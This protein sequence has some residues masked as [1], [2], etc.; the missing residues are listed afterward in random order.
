MSGKPRKRRR[1]A[2]GSLLVAVN[3]LVFLFLFSFVEISYR[4]YR[5]GFPRAFIGLANDLLRVPYSN[6]G[7]SNWVIYDEELGYRLNPRRERFNSRSVPH[8]EITVPRPKDVYRIIF[9]GD[10]IPW[11]RD[12]FVKQTRDSLAAEGSFEVINASVPGY[13]SYQ[14][15]LFYKKYLQDTTPDLLV[16]VYCLN[17]NHKFLHRFD[18]NARMLWTRE[19]ERTLEVDSL[20]DSVVSRSYL[21]T[22]IRLGVLHEMEQRRAKSRVNYRWES[23]VDFHI[24]WKDAPWLDYEEY[25]LDLKGRLDEHNGKLAIVVVPLESQLRYGNDPG[26]HDYVLK[27]QRKVLAL[28]EKHGIPCLDLYPEFAGQ[29]YDRQGLFRKK[30]LFRDGIHLNEEGHRFV[31]GQILRFLSE[32]HLLPSNRRDVSSPRQTAP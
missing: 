22:R 20:W 14:E 23:S 25:L 10:S 8:G 13:T 17:D 7:T 24:A 29:Y 3:L 9:L 27:P 4:I 11:D 6:L 19:A 12:G 21:L 16:W 26:D 15:V 5:D 31:T 2:K 18:E 30:R 28:C 1:L 32:N